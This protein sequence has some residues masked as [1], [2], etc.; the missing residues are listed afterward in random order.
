MENPRDRFTVTET[1][2]SKVYE[3]ID[4]QKEFR[5]RVIIGM[6]RVEAYIDEMLKIS[7]ARNK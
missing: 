1:V 2:V 6:F 7:A 5:D 4:T 3:V